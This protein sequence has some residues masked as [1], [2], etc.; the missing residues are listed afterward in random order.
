MKEV[1]TIGLDLAKNVFQV[2][3]VDCEGHAVEKR[4][5]KREKMLGYFSELPK[6]TIGIEACATAHYWGREL[7]KLGHEVRLI[8]PSYVKPY[9]RRG[10]NDAV[11]AAAICEAV[12]RPHMRFVAVKTEGQQ[13]TL[14]LHKVRD[15]LVKQRTQAINALRAHLAEFGFVFPIGNVGVARA[16]EAVQSAA[17]QILEGARCAL[18]ALVAQIVSF[19]TQIKT[20]EKQIAAAH[21]Q[22]TES[23]LLATIPGIGVLT[24]SALAATV[25]DAQQFKSGRELAAWLGLTP[26][27]NSSGGKERLGGITRQGNATLRRL[28][29]MGA[30]GQL[31]GNKRDKAM[32]GAW[33]KALLERK[34]PKLAAVALANKMARVAWAVMARRQAYQ[35][36][37]KPVLA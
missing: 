21:K 34:P 30:L 37:H 11:D 25:G 17:T 24:A 31:R 32:G 13:A 6:C 18:Q 9:V 10:K 28:L 5:L 36:N 7:A 15:L 19:E 16:I 26:R 35:E 2:H 29:V 20:L 14:M 1:T 27:Q 4:Q 3:G 33:F 8:P 23:Q 12:T 22:S